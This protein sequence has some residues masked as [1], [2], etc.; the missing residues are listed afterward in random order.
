MGDGE[1]GMGM[2]IPW[3]FACVRAPWLLRAASGYRHA[4]QTSGHCEQ[5]RWNIAVHRCRQTPSATKGW[6]PAFF[7]RHHQQGRGRSVGRQQTAG[8]GESGTGKAGAPAVAFARHPCESWGPAFRTGPRRQMLASSPAGFIRAGC[9]GH[10]LMVDVVMGFASRY[11]SYWGL[12]ADR[13]MGRS[14]GRNNQRALRRMKSARGRA[15]VLDSSGP[16]SG[17][18]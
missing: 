9:G 10:G 7:R 15:D 18:R 4:I 16:A 5:E 8:I 6:I 17:V 3:A 1:A 2:V 13:R 11:P 14:V 12:A